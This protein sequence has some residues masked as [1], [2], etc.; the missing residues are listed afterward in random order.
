MFRKWCPVGK[1]INTETS[2]VIEILCKSSEIEE[3]KSGSN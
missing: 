1:D 3:M 2:S